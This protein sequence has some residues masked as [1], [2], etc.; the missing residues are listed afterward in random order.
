MEM[1]LRAWAKSDRESLV[2]HANNYHIAKWLTNQFPYPYDEKA[3]E[4]FI[5]SVLH[6]Q[7]CKVFAIDIDGE[8]VG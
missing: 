8:A 4:A 1:K 3:G 6:E 7:P 2:K 5:D